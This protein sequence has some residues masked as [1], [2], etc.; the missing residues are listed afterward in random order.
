MPIDY[1]SLIT[2]SWQIAWRQRVLWVFGLIIALLS[3]SANLR[4]NNV[5]LQNTNFNVEQFLARNA[6]L[7][8]AGALLIVAIAIVLSF[9]RALAEASL[10]E[11]TD[12]IERGES[13]LT[14]GGVWRM[15]QPYMLK[16][17]LLQLVI[18]LVIVAMVV[19]AMVP[20]IASI[21]A[22]VRADNS[23]AIM[24][25]LSGS[26]VIFCCA[27]P[28][29]LLLSAALW[30]IQQHAMRALVLRHEGVFQALGSGWRTLRQYFA[31]SLLTML[32]HIG[33]SIA[34][35]A[36]LLAIVVPLL[37]VVFFASSATMPT[38]AAI[39]LLA[40]AALVGWLLASI[41]S[42]IPTVFFSALWTLLWRQ[43]HGSTTP[44]YEV[45][46]PVQPYQA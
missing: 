23:N 4:T 14:V 34:V 13:A 5:N 9:V 10:I 20:F 7:L 26:F 16:M 2:R 41:V 1:G 8:I 18:G 28:L 27:L 38:G 32:I 12:Q 24:G 11:A 17:W 30:V 43:L 35:G 44:T 36:V 33:F 29:I 45:P 39:A 37:G 19:L 25:A 46:A 6:V 21:V 3:S 42:A 31:P 40:V 22:A 15:G